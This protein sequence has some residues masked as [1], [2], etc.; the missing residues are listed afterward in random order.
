MESKVLASYIDHAVLDPAMTIEELKNQIMI[1]VECKCKTVC[2]NPDAI[3]LAKSCIEGTETK[4]CVFHLGQVIKHQKW[5][6]AKQL[7]I[8]EIFLK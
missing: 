1:G 7:L 3:D 8:K 6:N 4:L 2:V 5:H